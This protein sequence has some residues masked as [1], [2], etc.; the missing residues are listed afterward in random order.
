MWRICKVRF[1]AATLYSW[2][3]QIMIR[4]LW[5]YENICSAETFIVPRSTVEKLSHAY[6][7]SEKGSI[8]NLLR[9]EVIC[10]CNFDPAMPGSAM[11]VRAS[12]LLLRSDPFDTF[13]RILISRSHAS[14]SHNDSRYLGQNTELGVMKRNGGY[15]GAVKVRMQL[16]WNLLQADMTFLMVLLCYVVGD[17][18]EDPA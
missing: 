16:T 2:M 1:W 10:K 6:E 13:S 11:H 18:W 4:L 12:L 7:G 9:T 8:S 15:G 17:F 14:T 5:V 3:Y